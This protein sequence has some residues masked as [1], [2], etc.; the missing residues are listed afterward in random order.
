MPN[1][2]ETWILSA[3]FRK[4][5]TDQLL[6]KY[7]RWEPSCSML[8]DM[9]KLIVAFRK[10]A[11]AP[12]PP[13]KPRTF[14]PRSVYFILFFF[15]IYLRPDIDFRTIKYKLIGFCNRCDVFTVRYALFLEVTTLIKKMPQ[16]IFLS[17]C[18][19]IPCVW[20]DAVHMCTFCNSLVLIQ[21]MHYIFH[22]LLSFWL[23]C[24]PWNVCKCI[25]IWI[26]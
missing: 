4:K 9:T 21:Y 22:I 12:P 19:R 14:C 8:T 7:A 13:K 20:N 24:G 25:R 15:C 16:Y 17:L 1:F 2:N 26:W 5:Y 11:N 3:D 6:W 18:W 10:C 23:T